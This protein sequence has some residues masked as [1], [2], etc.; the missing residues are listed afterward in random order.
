[1]SWVYLIIAG[2]FGFGVTAA[3]EGVSRNILDK[4]SS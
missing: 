2:L 1:M 4:T 3:Q